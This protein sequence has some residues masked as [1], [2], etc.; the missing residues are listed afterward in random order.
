MS[1]LTFY[2]NRAGHNLSEQQLGHLEAAKAELRKLFD[3]PEP[4][5]R[6]SPARE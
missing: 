3:R 2:I 4:R 1:I 6:K 5:Q